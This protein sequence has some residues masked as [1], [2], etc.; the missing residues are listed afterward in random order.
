MVPEGQEDMY[1]PLWVISLWGR[2]EDRGDSI[3]PPLFTTP[4]TQMTSKI[5]VSAGGLRWQSCKAGDRAHALIQSLYV[6][7]R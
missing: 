1:L 3:S 5:Q 4:A 6:T 7:C 2:I